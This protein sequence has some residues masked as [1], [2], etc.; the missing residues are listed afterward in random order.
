MVTI[1]DVA[2]LARVSPSTVSIVMSGKGT[3]RKISA[4]TQQKVIAAA[5]QL[6]YVPNVQAQVLR[7][8][9]STRA[10]VTL[11]WATDIRLH[12][13]S[14]FIT[15]IQSVLQQNNYP[16]EL[17]VKPYENDHLH[18]ALTERTMRSCNGIIL[19]N[20][21]EK[22][23]EFLEELDCP[24]PIVLYNRYSRRYST[25]NMDDAAIGRLPGLVFAR[26]GCKRPALICSPA[27]FNGMNIRTNVFTNCVLEAGMEPPV[28]VE[29]QDSMKGGYD[30]AKRIAALDPLPDC[31]FC[32]SDRL[33][34]GALK[35]FHE[36]GVRIPEQI[37]VI[38]IGSGEQDQQEYAIPSLSVIRLPMEQMAAACLERM[39]L[40]FNEF[41]H[42]IDSLT[43]PIEYI[44]RESCPE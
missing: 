26:H 43:L 8:G 17:Q 40:H 23:M 14:R 35:G 39:L 32:T 25:V 33:A 9:I 18:E 21:S 27:T 36:C 28:A 1:K 10:I 19:C 34:L 2:N 24:V 12:M 41:S 6:G 37:E 20:A 3:E 5:Q 15:G 4:A 29:T 31:L 13:L 30:S 38:A 7:G 22:D 42:E 11:F 16:C 44:A